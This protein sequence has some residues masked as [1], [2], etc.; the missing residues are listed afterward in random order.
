MLSSILESRF[1]S[2]LNPTNMVPWSSTLSV[3][4]VAAKDVPKLVLIGAG[5]MRVRRLVLEFDAVGLGASHDALLLLDRQS[6]PLGYLVLP[7]LQQQD[8]AGSAGNSFGQESCGGGVEQRGILRAIDE[9]GKIA[10]VAVRPTRGFF[11]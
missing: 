9:A 6:F 8:G 3:G 11:P 7:L 4:H 5:Y 1:W 2:A 10:I